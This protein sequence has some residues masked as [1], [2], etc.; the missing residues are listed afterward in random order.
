MEDDDGHTHT[1][2]NCVGKKGRLEG[3]SSAVDGGDGRRCWPIGGVD[4]LKGTLAAAG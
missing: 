1:H 3:C 4:R 2:W